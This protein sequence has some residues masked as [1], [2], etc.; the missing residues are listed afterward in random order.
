MTEQQLRDILARV[1]PD[2]PDSV[3][4]PSPIV[5]AARRRRRVVTSA[6]SGVA[7]LAVVGTV[8][9]V[10][11]LRED[12]GPDV[13]NE[14]AQIA[15]P[16]AT[17]PCP[18]PSERWISTAVEDLD[19]VAAVRECSRPNP[20]GFATIE[21][22]P[23]ALVDDIGLFVAAVRELPEA[24]PGRCAAID[25]VP[26]DDKLLLQL[27]DGTSL[28]LAEG[29]C[30]DVEVEGRL[31]VGNDVYQV[32][33]ARLRA[34][35]DAHD[36]GTALPLPTDCNTGGAGPAH[37]ETETLVAATYCAETDAPPEE[38][39]ADAV[40]LLNAAWKDTTTSV[41]LCDDPFGGS[42]RRVL[43]RTD[44][45]DLVTLTDTGCELSFQPF[46]APGTDL[47]LP[48]TSEDLVG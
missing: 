25:P 24:D 38:L 41:D 35:R 33:L 48:V 3:A 4:D 45:G 1:V 30:D 15:D 34:Q 13:V 37:P 20:A 14:P 2:P 5:R 43:A 42:G 10:Q 23:D 39:D 9:G 17:A 28:G 31:L 47:Y 36:Y 40:A 12:P 32:L 16:Y 22:P 7:V 29:S 18:A 27:A 6:V 46:D 44:R 19:Q 8:F 26:S 11:S 21:G